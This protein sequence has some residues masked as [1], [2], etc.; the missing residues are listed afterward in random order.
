M[1]GEFI[2]AGF[3]R[4]ECVLCSTVDVQTPGGVFDWSCVRACACVRNDEGVNS[5][6]FS[7]GNMFFIETERG[8]KMARSERHPQK[9]GPLHVTVRW[10]GGHE[11]ESL[12]RVWLAVWTCSSLVALLMMSRA[13]VL[14][15][16]DCSPFSPPSSP[17]RKEIVGEGVV[18]GGAVGRHGDGGRR[19]EVQHGAFF[20]P[21]NIVAAIVV[22]CDFP[23][24]LFYHFKCCCGDPLEIGRRCC[25][26]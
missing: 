20:R 13:E 24:H 23:A 2:S 18:A 14:P 21:K 5:H 7:V 1:E 22:A 16:P 8:G 17:G 3:T 4:S 12:F 26:V 11:D 19:E 6:V 25:C 15:P 10:R 9:S